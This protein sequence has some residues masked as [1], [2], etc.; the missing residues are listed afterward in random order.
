[1]DI[2]S[3]LVLVGISAFLAIVLYHEACWPA[4]PKPVI[5]TIITKH[6]TV[7]T[8]RLD[9]L[10][11]T[12]TKHTTDTVNLVITKTLVD[13]Q[14][15]NVN[16]PPEER[17]NVWPVLAYHGGTKFGDTATITTFSLRSG[18][19]GISKVFIPGILTAID[20]QEGDT[21]SVPKLSFEPFA[22][23]KKPSLLYRL[24]YVGI[25]AGSLS[26]LVILLNAVKF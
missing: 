23:E 20:V 3:G 16:A 7:R 13:T 4:P 2:K 19:V 18:R 12:K 1:M 15:I 8:V 5:P 17:R 25:G 11:K 6:D 9:T 14:V 21:A 22:A 10:W 26:L 24:K